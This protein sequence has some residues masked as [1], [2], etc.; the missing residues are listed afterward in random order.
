M[1]EILFGLIMTLS[2]TLGAGML[3]TAQGRA[4][5][6]EM[7]AATIGC[8]L[9]WGVIDGIFYVLGQLFERGRLSRV[10]R[11]VAAAKSDDEARSLVAAELDESLSRVL[12]EEQRH[13]LYES[14]LQRMRTG[15]LPRNRLSKD[16]LLG[17]LAAGWLVF[18]CS[19]PA[20]LPFMFLND[21][22]FALRV[23]N[24]LRL[25]ML[26]MV[27]HR[28]AKDTLAHPWLAGIVVLAV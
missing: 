26:F 3:V 9:A 2:F 7:L 20:A 27:G 15:P 14:I 1:G 18:A 13:P 19:F 22:R 28:F 23:S 24:V 21:P 12:E 8:N 17:G 11:N 16:D 4:G 5:A 25:A 6:R 10:R